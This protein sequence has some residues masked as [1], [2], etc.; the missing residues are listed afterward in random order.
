MV[1][2]VRH[3]NYQKY[4]FSI[5]YAARK[6]RGRQD[7]TLLDTPQALPYGHRKIA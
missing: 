6:L 5:G 2:N 3:C 4:T 7:E 1:N